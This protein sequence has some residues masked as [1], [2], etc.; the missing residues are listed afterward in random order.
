MYRLGGRR[1]MD[2]DMD[3][4][5]DTRRTTILPIAFGFMAGAVTG[6]AVALLLAPASG[7]ETRAQI[8]GAV[9]KSAQ[10]A[11]Q[12]PARIKSAGK[13]AA[14]AFAAARAEQEEQDANEALSATTI[15]H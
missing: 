4:N 1:V 11:A 15:T 5:D 6:A 7:R 3:D 14:T 13:A 9:K 2:R 12:L 10:K 8:G